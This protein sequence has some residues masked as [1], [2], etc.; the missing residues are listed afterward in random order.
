MFVF[1][2]ERPIFVIVCVFTKGNLAITCSLSK[3]QLLT[4]NLNGSCLFCYLFRSNS[5]LTKYVL[6]TLVC[7]QIDFVYFQLS[8]S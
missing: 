3:R 6:V 5:I 2:Y 1:N 7:S 4:R 8:F